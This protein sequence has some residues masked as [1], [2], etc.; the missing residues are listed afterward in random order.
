MGMTNMATHLFSIPRRGAR[1]WTI[2]L[3]LLLATTSLFGTPGRDDGLPVRDRQPVV[4]AIS[5]THDSTAIVAGICRLSNSLRA[6]ETKTGQ[7]VDRFHWIAPNEVCSF[8]FSADGRYLAVNGK[9][10]WDLSRKELLSVPINIRMAF[11][12]QC[13]SNDSSSMFYLSNVVQEF[14]L[15]ARTLA[16]VFKPTTSPT[17]EQYCVTNSLTL[18]SDGKWLGGTLQGYRVW[19]VTSGKE[20]AACELVYPCLSAKMSPDGNHVAVLYRNRLRFWDVKTQQF[21]PVLESAKVPHLWFERDLLWDHD[22]S[23]VAVSEEQQGVV[24]VSAKDAKSQQ[25]LFADKFHVPCLCI[26]PDGKKLAA[27][28][29]EEIRILHLATNKVVKI[30]LAPFEGN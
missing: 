19:Q 23:R 15:P 27:A 12:K 25:R 16:Q 6:W 9:D 24:F 11:G 10:L 20:I 7:P 8:A 29:D 14:K 21:G 17:D 1:F 4:Q 5:F 30:K 13:F 2:A 28:N 22:S 26:S 18:S 3:T